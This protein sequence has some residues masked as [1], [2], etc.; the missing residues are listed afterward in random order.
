MIK[1]TNFNTFNIHHILKDEEIE[2]IKT[3]KVESLSV[4]AKDINIT[5][6]NDNIRQFKLIIGADGSNSWLRSQS[7][8]NFR[9]KDF[10][11]TAI[12]FNIKISRAHQGSAYQKFMYQKNKLKI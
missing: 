8:I 5:Y 1:V 6:A 4:G 7:S 3:D 2:K 10:D 9:N 11:Q 12:V